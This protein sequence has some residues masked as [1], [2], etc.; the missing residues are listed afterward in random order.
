MLA[1]TDALMSRAETGKIA[2]RPSFPTVSGCHPASAFINA[3]MV[4]WFLLVDALSGLL[5]STGT[6]MISA[7]NVG[8]DRNRK[9]LVCQAKARALNRNSA[10]C[11][12]SGCLTETH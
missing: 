9:P 3:E 1:R 8:H 12:P 10:R 2:P 11:Q 6:S 7:S 4:H 5:A